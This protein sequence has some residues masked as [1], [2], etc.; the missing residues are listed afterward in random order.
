[1]LYRPIGPS[2]T[3]ASAVGFGAWAIGGWAW[4]GSDEAD[5]IDAIHAGLDAG[6]NLIDTAPI[7]GFGQSEQIIGKA[8]KDRRLKACLATKCGMVWGEE[9]K[10]RGEHKFYAD[11][12]FINDQNGT[13]VRIYLHP[14]SIR[15]ELEASLQR[16]QTDHVDLYQTHWQEQTTPIE[17]TM[18]TLVDLRNEGKIRAIGVCNA[19]PEQ[20]AEYCRHGQLDSDQERYSMLDRGPERTNLPFCGEHEMAFLAYSPLVHGLLTGKFDESAA[21]GFP[22][23]D[24]RRSSGYFQ[25]DHIRRVNQMLE[26]IKPIALDYKITVAQLV[27][28]WTMHQPHCSH[29]LAGARNAEQA[30]AN[31]AAADV[32]LKQDELARITAAVDD[33]HEAVPA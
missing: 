18:A 2:N 25:P 16:L 12:K 20:M 32:E 30:R 29:V 17:D 7:Y 33:F 9:F 22:E 15:Q 31:A 5:A 1:M 26:S 28:A 19:T 8:L 11:D 13:D 23:G 6:M 21:E 3:Q 14:D 27:L 24:L 10:N 4:G